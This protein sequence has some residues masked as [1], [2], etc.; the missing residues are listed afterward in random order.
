MG[1]LV[2]IIF[3]RYGPKPLLIVGSFLHV[4]GLMMASISTKYYQFLL[5]QGM[6]SAIGVACVYLSA[7]ACVSGWFDKR[8]GLAFGAFATGSSLG[9]V[10]LPIMVTRLINTAG[11]GW[12]MRAGAFLIGGMCIIA[13]CTVRRRSAIKAQTSFT[14]AQLKQPFKEIPFLFILGGLFLIPFGLYTPINY[15]PSVT[16]S[17]G[18][19]QSLAQYLVSIYN[20]ASLVGRLG[21]GILADKFG[22][23]NTFTTSCFIAGILILAMWIPGVDNASS[24]AFAAMFGLF[25][26]AYIALLVALV[27]MVSPI[28]EIGYRNGIASLAQSVGGLLATPI[29]GAIVDKPNGLVGIKVYAGAFLLAGTSSVLVA[30]LFLSKFKLRRKI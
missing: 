27:A 14:A 1:P 3:D 10:V 26:G 11:Y 17:S 13:I 21:S 4:F 8:S 9:G 19:S 7:V 15:L 2:G 30:R 29:A 22:R 20:G 25:S 12:A 16:V 5:S 18:M 6:C 24:I 28:R 23:F